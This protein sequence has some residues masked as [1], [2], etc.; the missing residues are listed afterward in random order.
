M[1][2]AL[3]NQVYEFDGLGLVE[4]EEEALEGVVCA[5]CLAGDREEELMLCAHFELCASAAHA[6]C[7][8]LAAVP[9]ADWECSTRSAFQG[10]HD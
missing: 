9:E 7:L 10:Q 6:S 2:V 5:V 1:P 4:D 3:K 8:G